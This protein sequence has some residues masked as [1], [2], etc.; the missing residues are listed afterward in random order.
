VIALFFIP[1]F[2]WAIE[3]LSDKIGGKRKAT[4]ASDGAP[5]AAPHDTREGD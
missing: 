2:Y 1:M 5:A 3:T 4:P